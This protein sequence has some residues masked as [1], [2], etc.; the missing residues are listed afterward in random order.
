MRAMQGGRF[1]ALQKVFGMFFKFGFEH[2]RA[3]DAKARQ[4][5]DCIIRVVEDRSK[6]NRIVGVGCAVLKMA[7]MHSVTCKI[8]YLFDF[9]VD[10]D[11]QGYGIG[12]ELAEQIEA[13][14]TERS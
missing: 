1:P 5:D 7:R 13:V 12:S 8:G 10:E 3:F 11:Y 6:N 9:R 2:F 14:C 4:Y